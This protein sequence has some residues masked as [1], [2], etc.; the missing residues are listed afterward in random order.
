M[1]DR[2]SVTKESASF[3][4]RDGIRLDADI[5]RPDGAGSFPVLLMRQPYGRSIAS[6]VVYAH[7][8]WYAS[9]GYIVVIQDVRGR[10]TSAGYF[11]LFTNEIEDGFD[12]LEWVA[13][14]PNSTGEVGMYGFS[15][16]GMTQLYALS[17]AHPALKTL[18][19][20]MIAHDLYTDWAYEN[21]AFYLQYNLAWA[22]QLATETARLKGDE[23]AYQKLFLASRNLPLFDP[24][25][26]HPKI[27]QEFAPDSF[28]HDWL[29]H[30][31]PDDYWEK[32]SPKNLLANIDRPMLHIGGW[33][34][35]H[36]RGTLNL[37]GE[38]KTRSR[39]PQKLIIGPWTHLPWGRKVGEK[40]Y[41]NEA[42]SPI[43][44]IQIQW[45]DHF[46]K[47]KESEF[48]EKPSL[49]LFEMGA[50]R[51]RYLEDF[52]TENQKIYYLSSEGLAG[53]RE[54]D[55]KL[56]EES[57]ENSIEDTIVHDPWRPVPSI[58]GHSA[59]PGGVFDRSSQDCRSDILTYT[60]EPLAK[61]LTLLGI[62]AVE[63]FCKADSS[64]FDLCAI[65]SE[66]HPDGRVY[67]ISQGYILVNRPESPLKIPLQATFITIPRAHRL[68]LS[69]SASC[70]PAHPVNAGTGQ[71]PAE[72]RAIDFSIITITVFCQGDS[73]GKILLPRL[74]EP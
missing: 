42:I 31:E 9:H 38:M 55:G 54:D 44:R 13:T 64:S 48:L 16:Q 34:D 61:D 19:P 71:T 22:I 25:P 24:I 14:L 41:G 69:L 36:L 37:Y 67:N 3:F 46:L 12:T 28:Y 21:G 40:D 23:S 43:D 39:Y 56:Q 47:G 30:P 57:G 17:T 26:A 68:R 66:V 35:P 51:W 18:C 20:A 50:N 63:I 10:G 53:I 32:L 1:I 45:F 52:P 70:F 49:Y 5:Y 27:L 72:S 33:F 58:G 2:Y 7:P 60:T 59:L 73:P 6:T 29:H 4:T 74:S 11:T 15:Y 65:L 62:P 8:S